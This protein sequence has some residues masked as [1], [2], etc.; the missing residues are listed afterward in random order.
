M[1]I[2]S[3]TILKKKMMTRVN[4]MTREE[5][6]A[7]FK[8][9]KPTENSAFDIF[10]REALEMAIADVEKQIPKKCEIYTAIQPRM[11]FDNE[12]DVYECPTCGTHIGVADENNQYPHCWNCGQALDWSEEDD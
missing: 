7:L 4:A 2:G 3:T 9:T 5:A 10:M 6:I 11:T 12:V 8:L 1:M